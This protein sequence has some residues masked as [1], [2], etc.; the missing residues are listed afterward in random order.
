MEGGAA[1]AVDFNDLHAYNPG[2]NLWTTPGVVSGPGPSARQAVGLAVLSGSLYL[3]GG[4][5]FDDKGS[6]PAPRH[7]RGRVNGAQ[8]S[9]TA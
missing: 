7:A 5:T 2:T 9:L 1:A 3:F 6:G 8:N 4:G